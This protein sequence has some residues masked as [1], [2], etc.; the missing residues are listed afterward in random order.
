[1]L[2][3]GT[4]PPRKLH[5]SAC[6]ASFMDLATL[7][8]PHTKVAISIHSTAPSAATSA[9]LYECSHESTRSWKALK[10]HVLSAKCRR[11]SFCTQLFLSWLNQ[12]RRRVWGWDVKRS[13]WSW[14]PVPKLEDQY[15][16]AWFWLKTL[17]SLTLKW[18]QAQYPTLRWS[19][20]IFPRQGQK[21][22]AQT[23]TKVVVH[24]ALHACPPKFSR[25][26]RSCT[27][28]VC[29]PLNLMC[30][31][32]FSYGPMVDCTLPCQGT[33]V[34]NMQRQDCAI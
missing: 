14:Q 6:N 15:G 18:V 7:W 33:K 22:L 28:I 24:W 26:F 2:L 20:C 8:M 23:G 10:D 13:D 19:G 17:P 32:I 31:R 25:G 9:A 34:A 1:M 16:I 3:S 11:F 30:S 21:I 5:S 4:L 12:A 29:K 27:R